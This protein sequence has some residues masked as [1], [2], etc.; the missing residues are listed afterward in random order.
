MDVVRNTSPRFHCYRC[1]RHI[2]GHTLNCIRIVSEAKSRHS[3]Q[4]ELGVWLEKLRFGVIHK[5]VGVLKFFGTG[6]YF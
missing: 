1:K 6:S 4:E 5:K 3:T 2:L